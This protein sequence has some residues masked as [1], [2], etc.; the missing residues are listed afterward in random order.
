M[1]HQFVHV[2]LKELL[3]VLPSVAA[4]LEEVQDR[5]FQVDSVD[6]VLRVFQG[7]EQLLGDVDPSYGEE[8][9]M[10]HVRAVLVH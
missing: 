5:A 1:S 7:I 2:G 10:L 4:C 9:P 6:L 3:F 8:V